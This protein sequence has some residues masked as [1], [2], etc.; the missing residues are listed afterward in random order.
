MTSYEYKQKG[1]L[2][3]NKYILA[4]CALLFVFY[5]SSEKAVADITVS[6][7]KRGG[8]KTLLRP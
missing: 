4:S 8:L 3:L 6:S 1:F 2:M 5:N 7:V